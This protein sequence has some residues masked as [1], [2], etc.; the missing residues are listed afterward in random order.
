[1]YVKIMLGIISGCLVLLTI[2]SLRPQPVKAAREDII[3]I[4]LAK[5]GGYFVSKHEILS[6]GQSERR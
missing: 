3:K 1:M 4:D 5:I 2:Q 6:I